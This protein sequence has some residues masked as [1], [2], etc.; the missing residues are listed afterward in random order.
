MNIF[1]FLSLFYTIFYA[2]IGRCNFPFFGLANSCFSQVRPFSAEWIISYAHTPQK[3]ISLK[4]L[5]KLFLNMYFLNRVMLFKF[6]AEIMSIQIKTF[7][8]VIVIVRINC[9]TNHTTR[10]NVLC[11]KRTCFITF[12]VSPSIC[13]HK[14]IKQGS[15]QIVFQR[16]SETN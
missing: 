11:Y 7:R 9:R 10:G 12:S 6:E 2:I 4:I 14:W 15:F 13:F 1:S 8:I 3:H 16:F 5:Q